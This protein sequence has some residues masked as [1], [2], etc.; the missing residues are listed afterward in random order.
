MSMSGDPSKKPYLK[1]PSSL[2]HDSTTAMDVSM[3]GGGG[4]N[5]VSATSPVN[6]K[7]DE[8]KAHLTDLSSQDPLTVIK[9]LNYL[10]QR[11]YN[12]HEEFSLE[13]YPSILIALCNLLN[14]LNPLGNLVFSYENPSPV[15]VQSGC[16]YELIMDGWDTVPNSLTSLSTYNSFKA[17][18][19]AVEDNQFVLTILNILKNFSSETCNEI[20]LAY[21]E[22]VIR[23]CTSLLWLIDVQ[24]NFLNNSL[25]QTDAMQYCLDIIINIAIRID[26][27]GKKRTQNNVWLEDTLAKGYSK[28]A[29]HFRLSPH[30]A[31]DSAT[32][33]TAA[34]ASLL[35]L[36]HMHI[37]AST[38]RAM[39]LRCLELLVKLAQNDNQYLSPVSPDN[40]AF[41]LNK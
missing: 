40:S 31:E 4:A 7:S 3:G 28:S 25:I 14:N 36:I 24:N 34:A 8:V 19:F 16:I 41:L 22:P 1:L 5:T 9:G 17:Q 35:P 12:S 23:H 6:T 21:A 18:A 29:L 33:Y 10:S 11:S 37:K 26:I 30:M 32:S 39:V 38:S 20:L 15:L 13:Y 2:A 27:S